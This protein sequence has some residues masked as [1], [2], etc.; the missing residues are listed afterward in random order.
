ML[1]SIFK[2]VSGSNAQIP[3]AALVVF[4]IFSVVM[5]VIA[6]INKRPI[7]LNFGILKLHYGKPETPISEHTDI[8]RIVDYAIGKMC[9]INKLD[10][11]V[12]VRQM[13]FFDEKMVEVKTLMVDE[14]ATLLSKKLTKPST[15]RVEQEFR[16]Y[17]MLVDLML[18]SIKV[19]IFKK[20]M[21]VNHL[22]SKSIEEWDS[23]VDR[24]INL[25][26]ASAKTFLDDNYPED[27]LVDRN[28]LDDLNDRLYNRIRTLFVLAFR[29][30][31]EV[32][33][34]HNEKIAV[35]KTTMDEEIKKESHKTA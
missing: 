17:K 24:K 4:L 19:H 9:E 32:R 2:L 31:R 23:F 5:F 10:S 12:F 33:V 14:F 35:L 18:E 34:E 26:F 25:I 20:S 15:V 11:G 28:E 3:M 27:V 21:E 1:E 16:T 8:G 30:A 29:H 6:S 13:N 22:D 7:E